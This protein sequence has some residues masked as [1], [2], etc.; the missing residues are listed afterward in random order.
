MSTKPV[1]LL[2]LLALAVWPAAAPGDA[3]VAHAG[4][5][6]LPRQAAT[7]R[8]GDT[9]DA[10]GDGIYGE[11]LPCPCSTAPPQGAGRCA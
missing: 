8:A 11:S 6:R 10:D 3:P 9:H 7:Q 4:L 2:T 1:L 5:R